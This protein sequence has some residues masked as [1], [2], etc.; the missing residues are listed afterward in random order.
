MEEDETLLQLA[1][2]EGGSSEALLVERE[3][4]VNIYGGN[5]VCG[6]HNVINIKPDQMREL[7][8]LGKG[9]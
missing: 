4:T 6:H 5:V 3:K 2:I 7:Y 8:K 1:Q 9:F